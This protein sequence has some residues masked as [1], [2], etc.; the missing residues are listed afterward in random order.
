LKQIHVNVSGNVQGVGFR[1]F[2][3]M[4]AVQYNIRGWVRN[5]EDGSVEI[6]AEGTED[7]LQLYLED[8]RKGNPFSTV[9]DIMVK[10]IDEIKG[11]HSFKIK[12]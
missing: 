6:V 2:S 12:Y 7:N 4:K 3:Q 1:Y 10:E 8:V 11:Y 5:C 9:D